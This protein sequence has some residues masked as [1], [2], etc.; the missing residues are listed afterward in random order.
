M[1][2]VEQGMSLGELIDNI[3]YIIYI[4]NTNNTS[5]DNVNNV[6]NYKKSNYLKNLQN[7][8]IHSGERKIVDNFLIVSHILSYPQF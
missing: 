3:I 2:A 1:N 4:Y 6:D 7:G 5:V 8:V